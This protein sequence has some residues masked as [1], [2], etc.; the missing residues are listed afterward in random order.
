LPAIPPIARRW[1]L[2][3]AVSAVAAGTGYWVTQQSRAPAS[4]APDLVEFSLPDLAGRPQAVSQWRGKLVLVNFWATWCPPCRE[5]I[6]LFV[7]FQRRYGVR[8]FQVVGAAI[9]QRDSVSDF[10]RREAM[11]YPQLLAGDAG[12]SLMAQLGNKTGSLPYSVVLA[13]DGR[14]VSRKIGAYRREEL[15]AVIKQLLAENTQK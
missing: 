9:D 10:A 4:D 6:P 1:L 15:E 8:G 3:I 13:P 7:E 5:E 2:F 11:N 12:I 14:I